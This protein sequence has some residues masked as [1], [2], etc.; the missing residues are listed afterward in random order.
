MTIR[1][2]LFMKHQLTE[3]SIVWEYEQLVLISLAYYPQMYV[4]HIL[5]IGAARLDK[6][7]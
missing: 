3:L 5:M 7:N 4:A 1:S 2:D 6:M